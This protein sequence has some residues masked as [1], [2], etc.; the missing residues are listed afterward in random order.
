MDPTQIVLL[1]MIVVLGVTLTLVGIQFFLILRELEKSLQK[2]NLILEDTRVF[3]SG[4]A[5]GADNLKGFFEKI[6]LGSGSLMMT[7][8]TF[9]GFV[10]TLFKTKER[11]SSKN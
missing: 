7:I 5:A 4:L 6:P 1:I 10:R 8:M 3:S 11:K 2:T 9:L